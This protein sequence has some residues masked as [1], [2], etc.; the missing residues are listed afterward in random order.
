MASLFVLLATVSYA[1]GSVPLHRMF[2]LRDVDETS[3]TRA[4]VRSFLRFFLN[5]A[6]GYVVVL[7]GMHHGLTYGVL[8]TF[9]ICLGHN[10]P[11]WTTFRGGTGLGTLVG[12]LIALEPTVCIIAVVNWGTA[13]YVFK[14][15]SAAAIS[16][17]LLTPPAAMIL[18]LPLSALAIVPFSALVLW[19]HRV[20]F[21]EAFE[22]PPP[23]QSSAQ[24][25][26]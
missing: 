6:K 26:P 22:C 25:E 12:G 19:R 8:A 2:G 21:T 15:T 4:F 1:I 17:A 10:Y 3:E 14:K 16:T 9:F 13:Y 18:Q 24:L 5:V 7:I 23:P 11:V 20:V